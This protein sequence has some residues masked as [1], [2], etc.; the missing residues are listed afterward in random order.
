[1]NFMEIQAKRMEAGDYIKE[2][3]RKALILAHRCDVS[4]I[5]AEK[6]KSAKYLYLAGNIN[7]L[8]HILTMRLILTYNSNRSV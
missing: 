5:L 6:A 8:I 4:I 7:I 3:V 1:M 2:R